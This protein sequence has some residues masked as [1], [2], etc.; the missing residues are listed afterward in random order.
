MM[1]AKATSSPK[2]AVE[3]VV[4]ICELTAANRLWDAE[5]PAW[6]LSGVIPL[7]KYG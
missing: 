2:I 1:G 3:T 5:R 4:L 7:A 6:H